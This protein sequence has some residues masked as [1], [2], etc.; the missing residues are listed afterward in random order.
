MGKGLCFDLVSAFVAME[1]QMKLDVFA[2]GKQWEE[3]LKSAAY[4]C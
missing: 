1:I 2:D 4:Y 3:N